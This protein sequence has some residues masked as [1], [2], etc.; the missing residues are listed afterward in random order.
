MGATAILV[1]PARLVIK[2][3]RHLIPF[4]G[5]QIHTRLIAIAQGEIQQGATLVDSGSPLGERLGIRVRLFRAVIIA[6]KQLIF[7]LFKPTLNSVVALGDAFVQILT[8]HA[9]AL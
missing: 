9:H 7:K 8:E 6:T 4:L 1:T 5:H 2:P 3:N